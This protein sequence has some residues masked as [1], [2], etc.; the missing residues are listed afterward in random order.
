MGAHAS[1]CA[2]E[3]EV[4]VDALHFDVSR[5][6]VL[7]DGKVGV[8]GALTANHGG[9]TVLEWSAKHAIVA[10]YGTQELLR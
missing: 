4:A 9:G 5:A 8:L 3:V 6:A 2:G 7:Q 10:F 1:C